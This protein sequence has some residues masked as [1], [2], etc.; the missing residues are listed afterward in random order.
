MS[1]RAAGA[2]W[3]I[4]REAQ[5][6]VTE[7]PLEMP[8]A[9]AGPAF[10]VPPVFLPDVTLTAPDRRRSICATGR[11]NQA[12]D[13]QPPSEKV[14]NADAAEAGTLMSHVPQS[15]MTSTSMLGIPIVV[16][17]SLRQ[18]PSGFLGEHS[19]HQQVAKPPSKRPKGSKTIE[20]GQFVA[21]K[22]GTAVMLPSRELRTLTRTP[23]NRKL[24]SC[25]KKPSH[26]IE[27]N[28]PVPEIL[29]SR[30]ALGQARR[31]LH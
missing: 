4:A 25:M 22:T 20:M 16:S 31:L 30:K 10:R 9:M 8:V 14:M 28:V 7:S 18:G 11:N 17:T 15:L 21:E 12:Q 23:S 6:P 1:S 5:H 27:G 13:T 2:S 29:R 24:P 26:W 19:R 3:E